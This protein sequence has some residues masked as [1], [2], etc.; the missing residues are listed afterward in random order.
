MFEGFKKFILRGSVVDLAVGVV[1]GAAFTALVNSLV[2]N[3]FTPL[4]GAIA[5]VPDLADWSFAI[6][7]SRF[8]IGSF[9]NSLISFLIVVTAIYFFVIVPLNALMARVKKEAPAEI[10]NKQCSECCSEIPVRAKR[11]PFCTSQLDG[12]E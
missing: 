1:V 7:D 12:I 6:N 3:L 9:I 5:K 2:A 10:I 11:C 8:M 4:I